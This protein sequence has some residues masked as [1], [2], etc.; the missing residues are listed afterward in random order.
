MKVPTRRPS[1]GRQGSLFMRI[2]SLL[3]VSAL[4]MF[5]ASATVAD[6]R[7]YRRHHHHRGNGAAVGAALGA[8]I[9]L[10][11]LAASSANAR[12]EIYVEPPPPP[13]PVAYRGY[14]DRGAETSE[15]VEACRV[16]LLGAARKYGAYDAEIGDIF[17]AGETEYGYRVSAEITVEYPEGSRSS[18]VTCETEDGVLVSA[19][20][21]Y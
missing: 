14:R 12:E 18:N 19:R 7:D 5:V 6:A 3:A 1:S 8:G 15:A 10:G 17:E 13:P 16:G 2:S 11:A 4:S 20:S 9:F 21:E